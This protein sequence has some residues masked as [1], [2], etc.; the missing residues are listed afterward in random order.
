MC[1]LNLWEDHVQPIALTDAQIS[2]IFAA[3]HPLPPDRR[4]DFLEAC[5]KEIAALPELGDGALYR[6]IVRVQKLYF[7]P[8]ISTHLGTPQRSRGRRMSAIEA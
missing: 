4:S 3:S 6:M 7:D 8:P 5:A 1:S 2:A